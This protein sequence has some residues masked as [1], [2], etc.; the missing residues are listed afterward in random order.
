MKTICIACLIVVLAACKST[1]QD[2]YS[3]VQLN[4]QLLQDS[5]FPQYQS[6][7][8]ET[9]DEIFALDKSMKKVVNKLLKP[10]RDVKKRAVKLLKHIF[11]TEQIG[12]EYNSNANVTAAQ[13]YHSK[14]ANCMSLTILAYTL[15]KAGDM[16]VQFQKVIVP[17]YWVRNGEFNMLTG[18]VNLKIIKTRDINTKYF[19]GSNVLEIDFDPYA[20]K[21]KFVKEVIDRDTVLAMFYNNKGA[22]ALVN[23]DYVIA[24]RYFIE[25]LKFDP[26]YAEGWGNI[27]ILYRFTGHNELAMQTYE[28]ALE[29]DHNN[30]T[31]ATN[32]AFLLRKEGKLNEAITI[33]QRLHRKRLQNPYYHA[34]LADEALY[35]GAIES[36]I[37]HYKKAIRLNDKV[38]E[39]YFGLSKAYYQANNI[40]ASKK[41]M[42][43]AVS[44]NKSSHLNDD[45]IAKLNFLNDRVSLLQE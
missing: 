30:L 12:L 36:S 41:A 25:A 21:Q 39:F 16:N 1:Y 6:V 32:L 2:K 33:E 15:A 38:H 13:A 40:N 4:E 24:Y 27:G 18:H 9:P 7:E 31:V 8:I 43:K 28:Y 14:T 37:N 29:L 44:L 3:N 20:T 26:A 23:K 5:L 10:E 34:L 45:Y 42:K 17:E 11:E 35:K 19:W 22:A